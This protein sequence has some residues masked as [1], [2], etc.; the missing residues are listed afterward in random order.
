MDSLTV[1]STSP[2][3]QDFRLLAKITD[4]SV[5]S[6]GLWLVCWVLDRYWTDHAAAGI[7]AAPVFLL[8][9]DF[10]RIYRSWRGESLWR[11]CLMLAAVW[12]MTIFVLLLLGYASKTTDSYSRLAIGLWFLITPLLLFVWRFGWRL[13]A[14]HWR[15][16]GYDIRRVAIVGSGEGAAQAARII[17]QAPWMGLRLVGVF[18]DV[19]TRARAD[20]LGWHGSLQGQFSDL[21]DAVKEHQV[22]VVYI[23]L[24]L[25][26]SSRVRQWLDAL[27]DTT[28]SVYLVPEAFFAGPLRGRLANL[29]PL[30]TISLF[31]TPFY[32]LSGRLKRIED[33]VLSMV[34]LIGITVPMLMIAAAIKLTSPGPVLFRQKRYGIDGRQI[35]VWKFRSMT[36]CEDG[37]EVKQATRDD[38]RITPLGRFLRRSSLDELPQ[39]INVLQGR[40]SIVGP[41]PHA[42]SHNALYRT[43]IKGYMLRHKVKPG[44]TGWAQ[45]NGWRGETESLYKMEQRVEHDLWYIN[46]WSLGLDLRIVLWTAIK[47]FGGH[48]AY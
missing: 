26:S 9:S 35:E 10:F 15:S 3:G 7:I 28:V 27:A 11:E 5:I 39:F 44:I 29:G 14:G 19:S 43:L 8:L 38:P 48:N 1:G 22:D 16:R 34:I 32:G 47:G 40:M 23:D 4:V 42:L 17:E 6:A 2:D 33:V 24:P 37:G 41:R 46:N 36:V 18:D 25:D 12:L 20:T 13:L 21:L 31:E 45:I 30:P